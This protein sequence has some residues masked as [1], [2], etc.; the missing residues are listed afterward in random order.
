MT[1]SLPLAWQDVSRIGVPSPGQP[2]EVRGSRA[3]AHGARAA[4]RVGRH[5]APGA[6]TN[7]TVIPPTAPDAERAAAAAAATTRFDEA[8][9]A[10]A[11][12]ILAAK[13]EADAERPH[14]KR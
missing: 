10:E 13:G 6:A 4:R 12:R 8:G 3:A 9:L 1:A 14:A 7:P 11:R 5:R 2:G